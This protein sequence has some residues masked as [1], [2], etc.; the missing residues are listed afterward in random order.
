MWRLRECPRGPNLGYTT[1][2][3]SL[4]MGSYRIDVARTM[5]EMAAAALVGWA[6]MALPVLLDPTTSHHYS[7]AF[8]PW[9]RTVVEGMKPVS[10]PL[11]F[12]AGTGFG[13]W[14]HA[15]A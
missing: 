7:A 6:L 14:S 15:P 9:M 10:M 11:L 2:I 1:T 13:W 4:A 8:L 12:A 3:A 5:P